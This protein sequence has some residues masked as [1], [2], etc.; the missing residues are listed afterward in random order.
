[1]TFKAFAYAVAAASISVL[2]ACSSGGDD[3]GGGT[4]VTVSGAV[5]A[6]GGT[7][8]FNPP[9]GVRR[10]LAEVFGGASANAALSGLAA[11]SG[12]T[13]Q[14]IEIDGSGN[15]VG[16]P[17]ATGTTNGTGA[18]T[19]DA[20]AGFVPASK[21]VIRASGTGANRLDAMVMDTAVDVDPAS[22]AT[23]RLLL[24][25]A[26]AGAGLASITPADIVAA[27]ETVE[28]LVQDLDSGASASATALTTALVAEVQ[29][30]ESANNT[31]NSAAANAVITGTVKDA[32]DTPLRNVHVV[33]SD[34]NN[35]VTRAVVQTNASGQYTVNVPAG[36]YIVG[37]IN[38]TALSMA[39][40]EWWTASGGAR[41]V[42]GADTI[43]VGGTPVTRDFTL[44]AGARISGTVKNGDGTVPLGGITVTVRDF[45]NDQPVATARTKPDG[46]FRVNVRAGT[47][48]VIARNATQQP[49][50]SAV[51][52]GAATGG[53]VTGGG[54]DATRST[55]IPLSVGST[56]TTDFQLLAGFRIA[57]QV[58][59]AAVA[60][61]GIAVRFFKATAASS[62]NGAF[63]EALRTNLQG[64]YRIWLQPDNYD[65]RARGQNVTTGVLAANQTHDFAASVAKITATVRDTGGNPVP[66]AKVRVYDSAGNFI[67][68][69]VTNGDGTVTAYSDTTG[70]H[71]VEVRIDN[72]QMIGSSIW[73]GQNELLSGTPVAL[74]ADGST[75]ALGTITLPA[76]GVLTGVVTRTG[77]PAANYIVQVRSVGTTAA[78]RFVSTRAQSDGSYSVSLPAGTYDLVR[79]CEPPA[80]TNG[81][82]ASVVIIAGQTTTTNLAIP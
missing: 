33:V 27:Q 62:S 5:T 37:A 4:P 48:N 8:A 29:S 73:N 28:A 25:A 23:K 35:W 61:P 44:D 32:N 1:M 68:H 21:Y 26:A 79:A 51:F 65:V 7:V 46:S 60:Q 59:D 77:A 6:P 78:D 18:Y 64:R 34:F 80:C 49:F 22:E 20:P 40:S 39:A 63:V 15:Q 81:T 57:G 9:T 42:F 19:L 16:N 75:N 76:G 56:V 41:S 66:Q 53:T 36:N 45:T 3:Y 30:D 71:L 38:R 69:E 14:L 70:N 50:G 11:V 55:P 12:A 13:V 67:G 43:A 17:L 2:T 72:G 24:T 82:A 47:Y 52:N 31:I 74:T 10:M 58:T 54:T